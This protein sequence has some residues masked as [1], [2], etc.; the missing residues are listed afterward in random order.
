MLSDLRNSGSLEQDADVVLFCHRPI[1]FGQETDEFGNDMKLYGELIVAKN[2][3]GEQG[4]C[5]WKH[6][7]SLT[8]FQ[9][10]D[11]NPYVPPEEIDDYYSNRDMN[12]ELEF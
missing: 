2:R 4:K 12:P 3:E 7:G 10:W 11:D 5:R 9:P 6:N 1:L 8:D